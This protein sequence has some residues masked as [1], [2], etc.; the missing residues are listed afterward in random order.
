MAFIRCHLR[1]DEFSVLVQL[2]SYMQWRKRH[3]GADAI[4]LLHTVLCDLPI[5]LGLFANLTFGAYSGA[6]SR[7]DR[8]GLIE[9]H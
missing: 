9:F 7:R 6:E 4:H 3:F 2:V 8:T 5:R 1:A